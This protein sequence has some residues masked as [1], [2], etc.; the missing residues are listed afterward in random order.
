[1]VAQHDISPQQNTS[2]LLQTIFHHNNL[3]PA[4]KF[5]RINWTKVMQQYL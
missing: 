4:L 3:S 1:M 2:D 5:F